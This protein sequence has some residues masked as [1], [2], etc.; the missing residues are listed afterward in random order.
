MK[1]TRIVLA[2]AAIAACA[3]A[4]LLGLRTGE[5]TGRP[6]EHR[7]HVLE[8][9]PCTDC[10][11]MRLAG[12]EGPLHA[13]STLVCV[14]CHEKPHD[15][16]PC[17]ACH[18]LEENRRRAED[19]KRHMRFAHVDHLDAHVGNCARCHTEVSRDDVPL[20]PKMSACFACHEHREEWDARSCDPCHVDMAAE[21]S[22]PESHVIHDVDFVRRHGG[23]AVA[24]ADLC[25]TCHSE[26]S[27][28]QCHAVNTPMLPR[29]FGF[30]DRL[31]AGLHRAGFRSRHALEARG[32]PGLCVTCHTE[33]SCNGCHAE[34]GVGADGL[35]N[36]NPHPPGW[37][38][39]P[40]R[41]GNAHGPAARRD[42]VQ[43]A[44]C[45]G[46]A[47]EMLCVGCH[48]VG[49]VG[50]SPHPPGYE[51]RRDPATELPCRLCHE[52]VR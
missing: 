30:D 12:D 17:G 26:R 22:R 36:D 35:R 52:G 20:L 45:H 43:C 10:H 32:A 14:G 33:S 23:E 18:G 44:S 29:Q 9:I 51:S 50:G 47:G 34:V 2:T 28:A 8:G 40:G 49:G 46:G 39:L 13:P 16:R 24:A 37:V 4:S 1:T 42:P 38:G 19:S 21:L 6:F 15:P 5:E 48:K 31:Q 7:A 3:C 27:C 25:A 11:V 41:G